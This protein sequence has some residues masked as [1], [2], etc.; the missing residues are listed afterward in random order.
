MID[1]QNQMHNWNFILT[2]NDED[3]MVFLNDLQ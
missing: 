1:G 3:I 2:K